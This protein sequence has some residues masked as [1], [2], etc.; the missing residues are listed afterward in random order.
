[1]VR[2]KSAV[3]AFSRSA[4]GTGNETVAPGRAR[5]KRPRPR[6]RPA[7]SARGRGTPALSVLAEELGGH[8]RR[9]LFGH[10]RP[11]RLGRR[12]DP[13]VVR[14]ADEGDVDVDALRAGRLRDPLQAELCQDV[15]EQQRGLDGHGE[16]VFRRVEVEHA[17]SGF[18]TLS[19]RAVQ[20]WNSMTAWLASQASVFAEVATV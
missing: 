15:L 2:V 5:V 19:A 18:P 9:G 8:Q 12:P 11:D 7:C 17:L 16:P 14:P 10:Q 4:Q 1:M 3:R 6:G 20:G 13:P